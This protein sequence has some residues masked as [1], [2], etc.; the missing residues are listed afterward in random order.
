MNI[1][2][3]TQLTIQ[4]G[5]TTI[6][7]NKSQAHELYHSLRLALDIKPEVEIKVVKENNYFPRYPLYNDCKIGGLGLQYTSEDTAKPL[8]N[9]TITIS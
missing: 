4:I 7:L 2:I 5:D 9:K 8:D 1:E 6:K 3:E